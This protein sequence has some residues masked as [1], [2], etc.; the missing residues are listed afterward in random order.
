M[1]HVSA[2]EIKSHSSAGKMASR[3]FP[4]AWFIPFLLL[5]RGNADDV[6]LRENKNNQTRLWEKPIDSNLIGRKEPIEIARDSSDACSPLFP[7]LRAIVEYKSIVNAI[8]G[9]RRGGP[10]NPAIEFRLIA[11]LDT[12]TRGLLTARCNRHAKQRGKS[13][14]TLRGN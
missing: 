6:C 11:R 3:V 9:P 4:R 8:D 1:F 12:S 10:R 13:L 5:R 7:W 14:T 2:K